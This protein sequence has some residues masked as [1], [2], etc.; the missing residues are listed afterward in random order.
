MLASTDVVV[1]VVGIGEPGGDVQHAPSAADLLATLVQ[2]AGGPIHLLGPP[3]AVHGVRD[4]LLEFDDGIIEEGIVRG[5]DR[6]IGPMDDDFEP[7]P[8]RDPP[9]GRDRL[10]DR[11]MTG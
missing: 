1:F 4:G 6:A 9:C 8:V 2:L 10:R 11:C 3:D 7:E 5:L